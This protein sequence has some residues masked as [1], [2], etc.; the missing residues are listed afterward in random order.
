MENGQKIEYCFY[1]T[2]NLSVHL[3][4][5]LTLFNLN[6]TL[7]VIYIH[8]YNTTRYLFPLF[9]SP[10]FVSKKLFTAPQVPGYVGAMETL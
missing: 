2:L 8:C 4:S 6:S 10:H 5:T 9:T 1:Q 3:Y 7:Q